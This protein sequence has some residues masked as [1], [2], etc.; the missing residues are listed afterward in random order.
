MITSVGSVIVGSGTSSTR[1]SRFPCQV[2]AF[3]SRPPSILVAVGDS[4][5]GGVHGDVP[6][7]LRVA[8]DPGSASSPSGRTPGC[9]R[10]LWV[11]GVGQRA[12]VACDGTY[13]APA[14]ASSIGRREHES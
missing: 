4:P 1:M 5:D 8:D 14:R 12:D 7:C 13:S 10:V 6:R 3:M 2:T 11:N 9:P